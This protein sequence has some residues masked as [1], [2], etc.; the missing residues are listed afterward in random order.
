[1][2]MTYELRYEKK[3]SEERLIY[4]WKKFTKWLSIGSL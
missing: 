4:S 2:V 3:R 1:M